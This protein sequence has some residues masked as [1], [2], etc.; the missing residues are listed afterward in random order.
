MGICYININAHFLQTHKLSSGFVSL[1]YLPARLLSFPYFPHTEICVAEHLERGEHP[2]LCPPSWPHKDQ[3]KPICRPFAHTGLM[4]CTAGCLRR[5]EWLCFHF[6]THLLGHLASQVEEVAGA[7]A[8]AEQV[9]KKKGQVCCIRI[10]FTGVLAMDADVKSEL[11]RAF[12]ALLMLCGSS[13]LEH[14]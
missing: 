5:K 2:A 3:I 14:C 6:R 1:C 11:P 10:W 12:R 9:S 7:A 13:S 8:A 4:F